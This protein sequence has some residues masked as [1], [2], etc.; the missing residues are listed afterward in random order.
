MTAAIL[1]APNRMPI[2]HAA[3]P[4]TE[5]GDFILHVKADTFGTDIRVYRGRKTAGIRYP[6]IMGHRCSRWGKGW[7]FARPSPAASARNACAGGGIGQ[8]ACPSRTCVL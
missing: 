8:C 7:A 5:P 1:E 2:G 3:V 4:V 6:S